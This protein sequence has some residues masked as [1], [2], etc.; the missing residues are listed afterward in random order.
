[1]YFYLS[2]SPSSSSAYPPPSSPPQETGNSPTPPKWSKKST[3]QPRKA[4]LARFPLHAS[5]CATLILLRVPLISLRTTTQ[6]NG[7]AATDVKKLAEA[8]FH[9]V[10]SVAYTPKKALLAIKGISEA[11]CDKI[12]AEGKNNTHTHTHTHR[13]L[14]LAWLLS[15]SL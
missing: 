15:V 8:G 12:L 6:A 1:L 10:E 9:T 3:S 4:S 13:C 7:I 14:C 2:S 11:K 5:R